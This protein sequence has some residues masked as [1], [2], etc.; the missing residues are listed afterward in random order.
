ML[1]F[2]S[3]NESPTSWTVL[4]SKAFKSD[5]S[6]IDKIKYNKFDTRGS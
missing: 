1:K 5:F 2:N 6:T 3:E 4:L